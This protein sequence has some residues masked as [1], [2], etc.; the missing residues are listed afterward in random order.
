MARRGIRMLAL[1]LLV[2]GLAA[3]GCHKQPPATPPPAPSPT[4]APSPTPPPPPPPTPTPTPTPAAPA[5]QPTAQELFDRKSLADLNRERPLADVFFAYDQAALSDAARATL[6][7]N[8]D[9]MKQWT[10]TKVLI[11]GHADSRGT[12][13]YNLALGDR[14]SAAV[15]DYLVS[16]GIAAARIQIVSKG[17]E[18]PT[19]TEETE[20]CW[21]KNRRAAFEITA[22]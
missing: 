4:V 12:N 3:A 22:K 21:E 8:A 17:E 5:R 13:E 20:A 19:C 16:L 1:G 14:R 18:S 11:E 6:S 15:R 2:G 7:K 9:W 10:T